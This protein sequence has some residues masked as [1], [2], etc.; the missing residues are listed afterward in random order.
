MMRCCETLSA[1]VTVTTP[2]RP[3]SVPAPLFTPLLLI[4]LPTILSLAP[5]LLLRCWF[6]DIWLVHEAI[7]SL[8]P[9]FGCM[10]M[11]ACQIL[12]SV[13]KD[14]SAWTA[15][16]PEPT[17]TCFTMTHDPCCSELKEVYQFESLPRAW[18]MNELV[19]LQLKW[20]HWTHPH[21]SVWKLSKKE[22]FWK[23]N[24]SSAVKSATKRIRESHWSY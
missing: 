5:S 19:I 2:W 21:V 23:L 10:W 1:F 15:E 18:W 20:K 14:K 8:Q 11:F 7:L 24:L 22:S 9:F 12:W 4:F 13:F 6:F 17:L 16:E 3:Q